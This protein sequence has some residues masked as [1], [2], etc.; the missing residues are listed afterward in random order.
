[1]FALPQRVVDVYSLATGFLE[2][3]AYPTS[4]MFARAAEH[5]CFPLRGEH[6]DETQDDERESEDNEKDHCSILRLPT[7]R[8]DG[9]EER[10]KITMTP[11]ASIYML[12]KRCR[13]EVLYLS[14]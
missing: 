2:R 10:I 11:T 8:I 6:D 14:Q 7:T 12:K 4:R 3:S 5:P 1:M 9:Q 13:V